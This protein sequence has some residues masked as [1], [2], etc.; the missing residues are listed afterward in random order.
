[1]ARPGA[2]G[3]RLTERH[4]QTT[5][6]DAP[7]SASTPIPGARPTR[8]RA[9]SCARRRPG[10][11]GRQPTNSLRPWSHQS[12]PASRTAKAGGTRLRLS[13]PT[14][15]SS[16]PPATDSPRSK[17]RWRPARTEPKTIRAPDS[18]LATAPAPPGL[19]RV[20][21]HFMV[22][23]SR[24]RTHPPARRRG[25][26]ACPPI[27]APRRPTP[28]P[29]TPRL[30]P[31]PHPP[32]RCDQIRLAVHRPPSACFTRVAFEG[33]RARR[34]GVMMVRQLSVGCGTRSVPRTGAGRDLATQDELGIGLP[35][36]DGV[37]RSG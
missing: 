32:A 28:H 36:S 21:A 7:A 10:H 23:W 1:M 4:H 31:L 29:S 37:R 20:S 27:S 33:G 17:R 12:R 2:H 30:R 26:Q 13:C 3:N 24:A 19:L 15:S 9:T 5:T 14:S 25:A 6:H 16:P 18:A 8:P 34:R 22:S 35:L 11:A